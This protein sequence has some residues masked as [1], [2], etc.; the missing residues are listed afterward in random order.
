MTTQHC[1]EQL[2]SIRDVNDGD[3]ALD[4]LESI[5]VIGDSAIEGARAA[6]TSICR[7][8]PALV[9]GSLASFFGSSRP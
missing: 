1:K 6:G 5:V 3:S 2:V 4:S 7:W 9:A 8:A